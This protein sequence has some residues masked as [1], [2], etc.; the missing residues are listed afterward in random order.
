MVDKTL[1]MLSQQMQKSDPESIYVKDDVDQ[2]HFGCEE[3]IDSK[4]LHFAKEGDDPDAEQERREDYARFG[5]FPGSMF[6][7]VNDRYSLICKIGWGQ[8]ST[9]WLARDIP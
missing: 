4:L 5:Y 7:L 6:D 2:K 8:F 1:D 9:V 3:S